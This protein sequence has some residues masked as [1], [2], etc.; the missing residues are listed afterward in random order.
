MGYWPRSVPGFGVVPV[1]DQQA[2]LRPS[3]LSAD[4]RHTR[5]KVSP[6]GSQRQPGQIAQYFRVVQQLAAMFLR[7]GQSL[8]KQIA[9]LQGLYRLKE[10]LTLF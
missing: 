1:P 4:V 5:G 9:L 8:I 2:W 7:L 3:R 10:Q 6:V